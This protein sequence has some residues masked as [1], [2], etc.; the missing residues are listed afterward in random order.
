M[1]ALVGIH[2]RT[3]TAGACCILCTLG[4]IH[5][6]KQAAEDLY[7]VARIRVSAERLR[8]MNCIHFIASDAH[9]HDKR[10]PLTDDEWNNLIA[11]PGGIEFLSYC[12]RNSSELYN[13]LKQE[14]DGTESQ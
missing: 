4:V 1:D 6:F 8:Q 9:N 5:D 12:F 2:E 7:T 13:R 10:T 3:V 14:K 11:C